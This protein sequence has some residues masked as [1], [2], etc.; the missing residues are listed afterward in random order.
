MG[1]RISIQVGSATIKRTAHV[2]KE[3]SG[4]CRTWDGAWYT[5][6]EPKQIKEWKTRGGAVRWL[7]Q[8]PLVAEMGAVIETVSQVA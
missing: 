3:Y 1:F 2:A 6:T 4:V 7:A 8:R 5:S